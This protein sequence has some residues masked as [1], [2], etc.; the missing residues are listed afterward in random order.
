MKQMIRTLRPV[1]LL[2]ILTSIGFSIPKLTATPFGL[3]DEDI[4][5]APLQRNSM[6][7]YVPLRM[8]FSSFSAGKDESLVAD[9][10]M[11]RKRLPVILFIH[12]GSFVAGDR[13]EFPYAQIGEAFQQQGII[14]AVMSY[15]LMS[16]SVWPAQPR[17]VARAFRWLQQ[18][19]AGYGGDPEKIFIVGHSAGGHLAALVSTD[20][21]YLRETGASIRDIA[22]T[23]VMGAM[24][25]DGGSLSS[26]SPKD[27]QYLFRSDWFFKIFGSKQNF[28]NSLPI[29]HVNPHMPRMLVVLADSELDDPPKEQTVLEFI[30]RARRYD[31]DIRYSILEHR[32]HMGT[33]EKMS[34]P[35]DPAIQSITAFIFGN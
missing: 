10:L 20:S 30:D 8:D 14:C 15:R 33:V 26:L 35:S 12:G 9:G 24:M 7:L 17:D 25:S 22:G 16:D 4:S 1:L 2:L 19:I 28:I 32:T 29:R 31:T 23:V 18:N 34:D 11:P 5:Y 27:E 6:D 13:K 21:T 3:I